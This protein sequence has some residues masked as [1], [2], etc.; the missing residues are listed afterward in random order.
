[1]KS[2]LCGA[3]CYPAREPVGGPPTEVA[4]AAP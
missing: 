1:V 3:R 2:A 4:E